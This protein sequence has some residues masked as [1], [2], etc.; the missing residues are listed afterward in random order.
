MTLHG[1]RTVLSAVDR[2]RN[3]GSGLPDIHQPQFTPTKAGYEKPTGS[4]SQIMNDPPALLFPCSPWYPSPD[5]VCF[6]GVYLGNL[7]GFEVSPPG[8]GAETFNSKLTL[9]RF[10]LTAIS[11]SSVY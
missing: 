5:R 6:I 1:T 2:S 8:A 3:P 10:S 7:N 4:L 9:A 11:F